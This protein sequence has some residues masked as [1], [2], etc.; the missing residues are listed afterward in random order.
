[1]ETS[2]IDHVFCARLAGM[3]LA[4]FPDSSNLS[5]FPILY[6]RVVPVQPVLRRCGISRFYTLC[7]L[8]YT[9]RF[10]SAH[11]AGVFGK[12]ADFVPWVGARPGGRPVFCMRIYVWGINDRASIAH[13]GM[14]I[15]STVSFLKQ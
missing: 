6:R 3:K 11:L 14:L 5:A 13:I 2:S 12:F 4:G 8:A 15:W 9:L 7:R 10:G 1:V